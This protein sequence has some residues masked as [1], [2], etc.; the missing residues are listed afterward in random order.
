[1]SRMLAYVGPEPTNVAATLGDDVLASFAALSRVHADGWGAG[2]RTERGVAAKVAPGRPATRD[3]LAR[4]VRVPTTAALLYLRFGSAGT[5]S[6][7]REA[8]P[9]LFGDEVFEHNGAITPPDR[10]RDALTDDERATLRG[11]NDSEL[12][13]ARLR[14]AVT[15]GTDVDPIRIADAV[16][17]VRAS[18]PEASLNAL[19]LTP[20]A[21]VAV[22]SSAGRPAPLAAF[23]A[24]GLDLADLPPGHGDGYNVLFTRRTSSGA[25][26]VA[27]TGI[28]LDGWTPLP[29]NTVS[30]V[31]PESVA[32]T[33]IPVRVGA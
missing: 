24:R 13:F 19:L 14:R 30:L 15:P 9:F 10:L 4:A 6:S 5:G 21:L 28:P 12:Y 7:E 11:T 32:S 26:L 29:E 23:A 16:A 2:W 33:P 8:Q 1:M 3:A 20:S 27:T 17:D 22:H 31:T 18:Y 25:R